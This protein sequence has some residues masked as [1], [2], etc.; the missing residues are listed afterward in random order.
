M[1]VSTGAAMAEMERIAAEL[2]PGFA[3]EWIRHLSRRLIGLHSI[4]FH[5]I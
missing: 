5:S 2:P 1:G 4:P 3:Y